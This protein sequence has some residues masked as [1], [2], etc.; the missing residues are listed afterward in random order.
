MIGDLRDR[1][2]PTGGGRRTPGPRRLWRDRLVCDCG[3][4][5]KQPPAACQDGRLGPGLAAAVWV[6]PIGS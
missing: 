1:A 5:K 6:A 4:R 3:R 2:R